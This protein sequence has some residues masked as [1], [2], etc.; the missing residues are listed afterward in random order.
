MSQHW[1]NSATGTKSYYEGGADPTTQ[2]VTKISL[3]ETVLGKAI[4]KATLEQSQDSI[5]LGAPEVLQFGK[6]FIN[7]IK[8][9]RVL[10]VGTFTGASAAAWA[11][12]LPEDGHVLSLDITH[13]H[14]DTIG[15]PVLKNYPDVLKKIDFKKAPALDVL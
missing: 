2:Y 3:K 15:K 14:L 6:N 5:M 9:K 8:A 12:A 4:H 13:S 7:L 11:E 10:D 1:I